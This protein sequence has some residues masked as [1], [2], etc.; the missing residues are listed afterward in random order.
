MLKWRYRNR[1]KFHF[2]SDL[3]IDAV[4]T[5]DGLNYQVSSSGD[6]GPYGRAYLSY[7]YTE[8]QELADRG[9]CTWRAWAQNGEEVF[10]VTL[11]GFYVKRGVAFKMYTLDLV[12][13]G[14]FT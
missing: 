12:S 13:N 1:T 3:S 4:Y 2:K 10:T 6:T 8:K 7:V 14:K 11:Q 9:E 5:T